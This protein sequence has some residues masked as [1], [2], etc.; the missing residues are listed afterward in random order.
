MSSP[1]QTPK[2]DIV[3]FKRQ[4]SPLDGAILLEYIPIKRVK[5]LIKSDLLRR[6]WVPNRSGVLKEYANEKEQLKQ[7][8]KLYNHHTKSFK[9]KYI[10]PKHK[11]GRVLVKEALGC[12][13][14]N[15][16]TRNTLIDG[17]YYDFDLKN[18]Q[19]EIIRNIC[20][21]NQIDCPEVI[22]YCNNRTQILEKISS[23]MGVDVKLAKKLMLRL[24]FFGTFKGFCEE[25]NLQGVDEPAFVSAFTRRLMKIAEETKVKNPELYNTARKQKEAK[26]EKNFIGSFYAY[27]LQEYEFR[28]VERVMTYLM[29]ETTVTDHP[30]IQTGEK[31][32]IYEYDGIKLLKENVDKFGY[33]AV[34]KLINEKTFELTGFH[35]CWEEKPIDKVMDISQWIELVIDNNKPD[36]ELVE[37]CDMIA[38]KFDDTGVIETI[39]EIHPNNFVFSNGVWYSWTGSKWEEGDKPLRLAITYNV[40][41]YWFGLIAPFEQQYPQG[42]IDEEGFNVNCDRIKN[43]K[44]E[45]DKFTKQHLHDN[46]QISKC[47][48]QGKT[49]LSNDSIEFDCNPDLFGCNNG[50]LDLKEGVFRPA[51]FND[52]ITWSCGYDFTPCLKGIK[53]MEFDENSGE[54]ILQTVAEGFD[55]TGGLGDIAVVMSQIFP[56]A[57]IREL[58]FFILSTGLSGVAIEKFFVF[59]GAGRNGKGVLNEFMK[60]ILGRYFSYVSPLVVTENQKKKSSSQANPEI[61]KLDRIRYVI[62][63]EPPE[64]Q[65]IQNSQVKDMTGGGEL[66]ARQNYSNNTRVR[67]N[68]T[69]GM[70]VNVKLNFAENPKDADA[71]RI[72]DILFGSF[73]TDDVSQH[74]PEKHVYPLN[75]NLKTDEWRFSHRNTMLNL[76]FQYQLRFKN[77]G[78]GVIDRYIPMSVK[79]RTMEY[80][81]N[82]YD[83]HN[84]FTTYFEIPVV[85]TTDGDTSTECSEEDD[86]DWTLAKISQYIRNSSEFKELPKLKQKEY[87]PEYVKSFFRKNAIY[88]K[89]WYFDSDSKCEFLKGWRLK[90]KE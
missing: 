59:N 32:G 35:L 27:F 17:L 18:A 53:Y 40:S 19:P 64:N 83:I 71:E 60:S 6:D 22:E 2:I 51:R 52:Y 3:L 29:H 15:K 1:P 72:V 50:V 68:C 74:D 24:C 66:Q 34:V 49:L 33:E 47:V 88:K 42:L 56:D 11:W 43:I 20:I 37:V 38:K 5:A 28:I 21:A 73:F 81:Q 69:V 80:L 44:L 77:E 41:K 84:I 90:E 89:A 45:I 48:G 7:Y 75:A 67:L 31:V 39:A 61:A 58:M 8:L 16:A 25:N 65:L 63:K 10:K 87:N 4:S 36:T 62:M 23:T 14:F 78:Q 55:P 12:T 70:E 9:V 86:P 57:E 26:D 85:L 76:L 30:Y 82:S 13:A 54:T 46:T 79:K